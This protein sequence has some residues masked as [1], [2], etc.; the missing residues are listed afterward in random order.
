MKGNVLVLY[1]KFTVE[2]DSPWWWAY[3]TTLF[4]YHGYTAFQVTGVSCLESE[5]KSSDDDGHIEMG[6]SEVKWKLNE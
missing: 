1:V 5:D 2:I 4:G 3:G 6:E